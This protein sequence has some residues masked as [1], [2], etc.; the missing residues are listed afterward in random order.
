MNGSASSDPDND[1]LIYVWAFVEKPQG[2]VSALVNVSTITPSFVPDKSGRYVIRLTVSDGIEAVTDDIVVTAQGVAAPTVISGTISTATRLVNVHADPQAVDYILEGYVSVTAQLTIDPGVRIQTLE[3]AH[4][5][6][7]EGGSISAIGLADSMIVFNG[8]VATAGHWQGITVSSNNPNNVFDYVEV[9]QAGG[10]NYAGIY[11]YFTGQ[12]QIKH[13]YFHHNATYGFQADEN[14]K[15]TAFVENTFQNNQ[16]AGIYIPSSHIGSIDA[17]STYAGGNTAD[18][19]E[20]GANTVVTNQTWQKTDAPYRITNTIY[21]ESAVTVSPGASFIFTEYA[22][23]TVNENGSLKAVGTEADSIRFRGET[24]TA[25]YWVGLIFAS[26]DP[27]NILRYVSISDGG[28]NDYANVYLMYTSQAS[29]SNCTILRSGTS[30]VYSDEEVKLTVFA[31]NVLGQNRD[32]PLS[33]PANLIGS[34][35][36][37][38]DYSANN[39]G[40]HNPSVRREC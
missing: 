21:I 8:S 2:S 15:I 28:Y 6:I 12:A 33:I 16:I 1:T 38:S 7:D 9:A 3:N 24:S 20:V 34:I 17:A 29:I 39:G 19:I 37:G 31:N 40:K 27:D 22:G 4:L 36:S 32:Y 35:D 5:R 30:G 23:M 10:N 13:S 18:V 14:S 26:N 25:G 11:L